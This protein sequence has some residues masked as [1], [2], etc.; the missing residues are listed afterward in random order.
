MNILMRKPDGYSY[1]QFQHR[2]KECWYTMDWH[3]P[4]LFIGQRTGDCV[5]YSLKEG[6]DSV[7]WE[8]AKL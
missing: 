6:N 1:M 5:G 4:D 2:F 3:M 7:L 8:S